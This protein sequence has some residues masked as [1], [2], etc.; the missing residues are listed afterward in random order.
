MPVNI[1]MRAIGGN[2]R[3]FFRERRWFIVLV[4]PSTK[5]ATNQVVLLE[6]IFLSQ[7]VKVNGLIMEDIEGMLQAL[8][9]FLTAGF[10]PGD[11]APYLRRHLGQIQGHL[12]C[13]II[14]RYL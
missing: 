9:S 11:H 6:S 8:F 13:P 4:S 3:K 1:N 14:S 12:F 10:Q 2:D 7:V 5:P